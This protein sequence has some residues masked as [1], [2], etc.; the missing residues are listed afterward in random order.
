M[1]IRAT[2]S[3]THHRNA[4]GCR[5]TLHYRAD[6]PPRRKTITEDSPD[7]KCFAIV[8]GKIHI[9]C[10][11]LSSDASPFRHYQLPLA[12]TTANPLL[13]LSS[14]IQPLPISNYTP[15]ITPVTFTPPLSTSTPQL[16]PNTPNIDHKTRSSLP[17]HTSSLMRKYSYPHP[18]PPSTLENHYR[19]L[20]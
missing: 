12:A 2:M 18:S 10:V 1:L 9:W 6:W 4:P 8:D 13:P 3:Y 5:D 11:V 19:P 17:V 7:W 14:S 16:H 15:P 20:I